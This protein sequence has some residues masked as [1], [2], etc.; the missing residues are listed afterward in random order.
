[1]NDEDRKNS[2]GQ[3]GP[4]DE[5]DIMDFDPKELF[6]NLSEINRLRQ[7]SVDNLKQELKDLEEGGKEYNQGRIEWIKEEL[8]MIDV[9][10]DPKTD[11]EFFGDKEKDAGNEKKMPSVKRR[12]RAKEI[13]AHIY[14]SLIACL[15][16]FIAIHIFS[17]TALD[18]N[19]FSGVY[20]WTKDMFM[21]T[22]GKKAENDDFEIVVSG[23]REYTNLDEFKQ[24]EKIDIIVPDYISGDEKIKII[25]CN[26]CSEKIDITYTGGTFLT[27]YLN[28]SLSD[29]NIYND[30]EKY[31]FNNIDYYILKKNKTITWEHG[32]NRYTLECSDGIDEYKKIIEIIK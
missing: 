17:I 26:F 10:A 12:K 30:V 29:L 24:A 2:G 9:E 7:I 13:T 3:E 15:L 14:K 32:G 28:T 11:D 6:K 19:I 31:N 18:K 5:N 8:S 4:E 23:I 22:T 25:K 27:I 1:M 20:T 16:F 21:D